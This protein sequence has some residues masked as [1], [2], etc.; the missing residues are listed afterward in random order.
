MQKQAKTITK[1]LFFIGIACLLIWLVV[2]DLTAEDKANV[3]EAFGKAKYSWIIFSIFL[4]FLSH[5]S[6]AM[7]WRMLLQPLGYNPKTSNTFFAVM[8]G[9]LANFALPRLGEVSRCGVLTK[10]EKI[11]F[12]ESFGTVITERVFDVICL[13]IIFFI[14]LYTQFEKI[15]TH[16]SEKIITPLQQKLMPLFG[17]KGFALITVVLV[18]FIIVFIFLR[19][20]KSSNTIFEKMIGFA[21]GFWQGIKSIRNLKNPGLFIFHSVFIWTMYYAI[22]HV[23]FFAFEETSQ[24]GVGEALAVLIFGSV[25]IIFVPGGTGAYQLLVTD[26]L[27]KI[28]LISFSTAFAFSW[29]VW[30]SSLVLIV[31]LGVLSLI[32]LPILNKNEQA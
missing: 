11:P 13:M 28:Y 8:I 20:R 17:G 24:L 5:L 21:M 30:S 19:K 16:V 7:R 25:G 22:V 10:Y 3:A 6:R 29:I 26:T 18:L 23:S 14:T 2:K 12:T 27:T 9:Y 1:F 31:L 15:S 4:S 32:L